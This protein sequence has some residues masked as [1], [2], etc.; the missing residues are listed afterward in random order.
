MCDDRERRPQFGFCPDL[1]T[2]NGDYWTKDNHKYKK[3]AGTNKRPV[4]LIQQVGIF[5]PILK[6]FKILL[7]KSNQRREEMAKMNKNKNIQ[8]QGFACGHPPYY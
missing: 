3:N 7:H 5:R 2:D 1:D 8:Q 6:I 4:Y